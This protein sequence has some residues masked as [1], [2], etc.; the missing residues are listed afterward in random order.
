[1][2]V[3][4][5]C[6]FSG[7]VRD[8][9]ISKGHD[10]ISCDVLP[11]DR[12]GPHIQKDIRNIDITCYDMLIAF[13]PCTFL[14]SSCAW[15]WKY[16]KVEQKEA[17]DFV[18]YLWELPVPYIAIENPVGIL[19][20]IWKKPSQILQPWQYG[21][22]ETKK[23]CLWLKNLPLLFP[24]KIVKERYPRVYLEAPKGER[25]KARSRTY[26]GIARAMA[27]QWGAEVNAKA[28]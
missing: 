18:L 13:P 12:K 1:M 26:T 11:S 6:E 5:G 16:R 20:T 27:N 23:T 14:C 15:R 28:L 25:W 9:F 10:A 4:V 24:E 22:G 2:K 7:R 19:S 17:I 21:H 8:A 3:L